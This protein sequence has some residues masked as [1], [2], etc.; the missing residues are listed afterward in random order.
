MQSIKIDQDRNFLNIN[1][2]AYELQYLSL[3]FKLFN[4]KIFKKTINK[5]LIKIKIY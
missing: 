2:R 5:N 1:I 3:D 4:D